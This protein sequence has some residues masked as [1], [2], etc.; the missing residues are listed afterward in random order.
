MRGPPELI[1]DAPVWQQ[2]AA[3]VRD[4]L[5]TASAGL[6]E[7][8]AGLLPGLVV[9]DDG[10]LPEDLR[11]DMRLVGMSH[12]T[13][14][15]G[16]NLAIVTG[17]IL[18]AARALRVRRSAA[19]ALAAV[20]LLGFVVVVGPQPSVLR[21]AVM[22]LIALAAIAAGRTGQGFQVLA[23]A[24]VIL[25]LL[26]PGL[27]I[28]IGFALSVAATG[29]LLAYAARARGRP[30]LKL[31]SQRARRLMRDA[32]AVT[33]AA[34]LATA[35]LVAGIGGGLPLIGV[36]A[37][38]LAAP[39]VAPATIVGAAAAVVGLISP[40]AAQVLAAAAGVPTQW[41][42]GVARA[43]ADV[44]GGV[45]PWPSGI[46][47]C[48]LMLVA[49]A[50]AVALIR[51]R[52]RL[53][54]YRP[55]ALALATAL[56]ALVVFLIKPAPSGQWPPPG[57]HAVICDVGQG[58]A[59]V[60]ATA[61]GHAIVIDAGPDPKA[62]DRCLRD[63]G[64][65]TI[66]LL[67]L[68]HFHAD[69]V[70]GIPGL[71]RGRSI[72]AVAVSPLSEPLSE[73]NRVQT[74]LEPSGVQIEAVRPG[75]EGGIGPVRYRYLWPQRILRSQGSDPNNAS[76]TALIDIGD[77]RI[78]M[79]GDLEPAA[80]EAMI[81]ATGPI[82]ADVVKIP[83]HGSRNQS[84]RLIP[85]SGAGLAIASAG[86]GNTYGHPSPVTLDA[87]RAAGAAIGRTDRNSDIAIVALPGAVPALV[88]RR[89]D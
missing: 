22:G 34:Q 32:L 21:A 24:V 2:G 33:L 68:T 50:A 45:L 70:E 27:A 49:Y 11:E 78:L 13:A 65:E 4:S 20:G 76:V 58:D 41:I 55:A 16:A 69:H 17:M 84:P 73:Y 88:P 56:A 1:S 81:S 14:V 64:I 30:A 89:S 86:A 59:S 38:L 6:P 82:A 37:N 61:P 29:G 71:L 18:L 47:G 74:W 7:D 8:A 15:S 19:C 3:A 35:P 83:H 9:G 40:A 85:W 12:L 36:P 66:D 75:E 80:Q 63:L 87:W 39:A 44:P 57:W 53:A 46:A 28:S 42:A 51:E 25:L 72:G 26:D 5:V 43:A 77:L 62:A 52:R 10:G 23:A 60:F 54:S 67:I 79:P 31:R 48:A